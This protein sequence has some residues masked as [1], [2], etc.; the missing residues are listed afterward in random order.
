MGP[1]RPDPKSIGKFMVFPMFGKVFDINFRLGS[2]GQEIFQYLYI[3]RFI[4]NFFRFSPGTMTPTV[5]LYRFCHYF[6][7]FTMFWL[8]FYYF[9]GVSIGVILGSVGVS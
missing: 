3:Y 6:D 5:D 8:Y 7:V 2:V 1:N 9:F 4:C